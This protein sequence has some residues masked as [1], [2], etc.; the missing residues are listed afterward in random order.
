MNEKNIG[1]FFN[2]M[3]T[4]YVSLVTIRSVCFFFS[5]YP[6]VH[7]LY[8]DNVWRNKNQT[9]TN[10]QHTT[11][12]IRSAL[13]QESDHNS[14]QL[15]CSSAQITYHLSLSKLYRVG[16]CYLLFVINRL[17]KDW[18]LVVG[19]VPGTSSIRYFVLSTYI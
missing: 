15:K 11:E 1:R 13:S 17:L 6:N 9:C 3:S 8:V 5:I 18:Y 10:Y 2:S 14:S 16:I 19:K 7:L 12:Q 4:T